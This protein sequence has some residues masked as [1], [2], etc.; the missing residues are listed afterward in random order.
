MVVKVPRHAKQQDWHFAGIVF[1]VV[2]FAV[3][4]AVLAGFPVQTQFFAH[5]V[6]SAE[7]SVRPSNTGDFS[8]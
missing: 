8:R 4:L 2:V 6:H 3:V 5:Q 7:Q 1:A